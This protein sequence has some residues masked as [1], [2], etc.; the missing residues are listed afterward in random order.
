MRRIYEPGHV[1]IVGYRESRLALY[2]EQIVIVT[3]VLTGSRSH[4]RKIRVA[5]KVMK[6]RGEISVAR[7]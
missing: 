6:Y 7:V 5:Y 3:A 2:T 4:L 1:E